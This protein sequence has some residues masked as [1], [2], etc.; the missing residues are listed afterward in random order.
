M[1]MT[2]TQL[3]ENTL[4]RCA[5][6]NVPV[7]PT[8]PLIEAESALTPRAAAEVAGRAIAAGYVAALCFGGPPAPIRRH[9]EQFDLWRFVSV[10]EQSLFAPD[11]PMQAKSYYAWLIE[12]IQ[13]FAWSL[14]L[15]DLDHFRRCDDNL[16]SRFPHKTDPTPFIASARLRPQDE[17]RQ[18]SDTL[19]MLHWSAADANLTGSTTRLDLPMVAFRRHAADWVVGTREDWDEVSLDT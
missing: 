17:L 5:E 6:W 7:N 14:A 2:P 4:H 3:R 10:K 11:A 13:F 9:L 19:Y 12:S 18:E 15:A 1:L 8:L 16:S